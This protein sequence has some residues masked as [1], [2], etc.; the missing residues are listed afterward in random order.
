[1]SSR[2]L[3][4]SCRCAPGKHVH[5]AGFLTGFHP[6]ED[7]TLYSGL[8]SALSALPFSHL[9]LSIKEE[10]LICEGNLSYCRRLHHS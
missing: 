8:Y 9:M 7:H 2:T 6:A 10:L 4:D 1:M 5:T 3:S